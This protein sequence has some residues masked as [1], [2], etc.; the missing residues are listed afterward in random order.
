MTPVVRRSP[1]RAVSPLPCS[2][3]TCRFIHRGVRARLCSST[4]TRHHQPASSTC[5]FST[6]PRLPKRVRGWSLFRLR[7]HSLSPSCARCCCCSSRPSRRASSRGA[8]RCRAPRALCASPLPNRGRSFGR[9][10]SRFG[11]AVFSPH[12]DAAGRC[13]S[14][15]RTPPAHAR[16]SSAS[17]RRDATHHG[18]SVCART[19]NNQALAMHVSVLLLF[20]RAASGWTL[21]YFRGGVG[22]NN[23]CNP[24]MADFG[25]G[26][27]PPN[28]D[29]A[30]GEVLGPFSTATSVAA[31][32]FTDCHTLQ[33]VTLI[34]VTSI[35]E[36]A[37]Q[38]CNALTSVAMPNLRYVG[39]TLSRVVPLVDTVLI[40]LDTVL[41]KSMRSRSHP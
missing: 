28:T 36:Y 30:G 1:L 40:P 2:A 26:G 10:A 13:A 37:F 11:A 34:S 4:Q 38:G 29:V 24:Q 35:G 19:P 23:V 17:H 9:L 22:Q 6:G 41:I 16:S 12:A 3:H 15:L 32:A 39:T 33:S 25:Q 5:P 14:H 18:R 20:F 31:Q 8:A 27:Y 21:T 7:A